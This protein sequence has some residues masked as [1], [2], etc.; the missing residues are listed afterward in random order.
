MN[1]KNIVPTPV[2]NYI[3]NALQNDRAL[4]ENYDALKQDVARKLGVSISKYTISRRAGILNLAIPRGRKRTLSIEKRSTSNI[5]IDCAGAFFLKGAELETN[6]LTTVNQLLVTENKSLR[7]R[8]TLRLARDINAYLLYLPLAAGVKGH[9]FARYVRRGMP[10][11][12]GR[13]NRPAPKEIKQYLEFLD[14][15]NLWPVMVQEIEKN[16]AEAAWIRV[17]NTQGAFFLDAQGRTVWPAA[18]APPA[19]TTTL[20]KAIRYVDRVFIHP[21]V[22]RAL[23][24]QTIP[25]DAFLAPEVFSLIQ[26]FEQG[27]AA[28]AWRLSI[29]DNLGKRMT[30]D[31]MSDSPAGKKYFIFPL[32]TPQFAQF[33]K[34]RNVQGYQK[35]KIG[36]E[37]EIVSIAQAQADLFKNSQH[38]DFVSVRAIIVERESETIALVTNIP[39]S[40][41]RYAKKIVEQ[42]FDCRPLAGS[43]IKTYD[44]IR[45]EAAN[46][47]N[48]KQPAYLLPLLE[49]ETKDLEEKRNYPCFHYFFPL[50]L[51]CLHCY[52][53]SHFFPLED[54]KRSLDNA[55]E[56]IYRQGGYM[57]L[58]HGREEVY[59]YSFQDNKLQQTVGTACRNFNQSGIELSSQNTLRLFTGK[60]L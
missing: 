10:F 47:I 14:A 54:E 35:V 45:E 51:E 19:F 34:V 49:A 13:T 2:K 30:P 33:C 15:Q 36:A 23:A 39:Y 8:R 26:C 42:Y 58:K 5:Y 1:K 31:S 41:E 17:E 40:A 43:K 11:L 7:A 53:Q 48:W 57:K 44:N 18:P 9:A 52:A 6:I 27:E 56:K 46:M 50:L 20:S 16:C 60:N 55:A 12:T 32:R 3:D 24:L 21:A 4:R 38:T 29:L 25:G 37:E 59:L 28:G 22:R